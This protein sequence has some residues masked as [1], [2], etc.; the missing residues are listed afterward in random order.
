MFKNATCSIFKK[1][2]L[3][4]ATFYFHL[5][6]WGFDS[7]ALCSFGSLG[8]VNIEHANDFIVNSVFV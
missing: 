6:I 3:Q 8:D 4:H 7:F 1:P 5:N 2:V